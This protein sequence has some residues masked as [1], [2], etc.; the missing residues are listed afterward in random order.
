MT[1]KNNRCFKV[2]AFEHNLNTV[3]TDTWKG[4]WKGP[5]WPYA[6]EYQNIQVSQSSEWQVKPVGVE[7]Y[8]IA[9]KCSILRLDAPL[10]LNL[11]TYA[12]SKPL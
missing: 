11:Q 9:Q 4:L 10:A 2:A 5:L 7:L 12:L 6:N 3:E 1:V 8:S